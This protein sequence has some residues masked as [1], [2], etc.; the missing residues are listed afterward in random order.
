MPNCLVSFRVESEKI[1][2][3]T[4]ICDKLGLDL[5]TYLRLCISRLIKED[6]I[7]FSM[8]LDQTVE[9]PDDKPQPVYP[10]E[11]LVLPTPSI[12]ESPKHKPI[13]KGCENYK[14]S[15]ERAIDLCNA[16]MEFVEVIETKTLYSFR[17]AS[18][19]DGGR[20]IS[21]SK[22][23][24]AI[25]EQLLPTVCTISYEGPGIAIDIAKDKKEI[26]LRSELHELDKSIKGDRLKFVVGLDHNGKPRSVSLKNLP[27]LLIGGT[28]GSGKSIFL[29]NLLVE[30]LEKNTP[31]QLRLVLVDP[32]HVEFALYRD[33]PNLLCPIIKDAKLVRS[34]I[35]K[36][37]DEME[38]R[39]ELFERVGATNITQYNEIYAKDNNAKRLPTILMVIDE[40]A[41]V[42]DVDRNIDIAIVRLVQKSRSAGIHLVLSTQR[43]NMNTINGRIKANVSSV[44]AFSVTN[45]LDSNILL[46]EPGAEKLSGS[47]D[48]LVSIPDISK[49]GLTRLQ[50]PYIRMQEVKDICNA[51]K[52]KYKQDYSERF[53]NLEPIQSEAEQRQEK[54]YAKVKLYIQKMDYISIGWLQRSLGIGFLRARQIMERLIKEGLVESNTG[55]QDPRGSRVIHAN[56]A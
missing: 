52:S 25:E 13:Q 55:S 6:G 18:R 56:K 19:F 24:K 32:K 16:T 30:L 15:I 48:M 1:K 23:T 38:K 33:I 28:T 11:D 54:L 3:A 5:P 36:L 44:I 4:K 35:E 42:V 20:S 34:C 21:Y 27:H 17:Y 41:D 47:G 51:L 7:P 12:D 9:F 14:E 2:E 53:L 46:I 49:F 29:H 45:Q 39:Y 8:K 10:I 50:A 40:Y 26:I 31:D 37:I 43:T 22:L